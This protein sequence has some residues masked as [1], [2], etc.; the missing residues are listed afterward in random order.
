MTFAVGGTPG[1]TVHHVTRGS[2]LLGF[3]V[4]DST[5]AGRAR[6]GL[7]MVPDV[8]ETEIRLAARAMTLKCA[9]LGLPQGG[10]KA[11]IPRRRRRGSAG[12]AAAAS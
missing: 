3:V 7:R 6:G 10:A 1:A 11:G 8:F 12:Q 9:L 4:I 5:V 2:E